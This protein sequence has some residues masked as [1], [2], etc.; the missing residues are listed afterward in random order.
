MTGLQLRP[1]ELAD[2]PAITALQARYDVHWFGAP[3]RDDDEMAEELDNAAESIVVVDGDSL[4]AIVWTDPPGATLTIDPTVPSGPVLDVALGWLKEREAK[5]EVLSRDEVLRTA[6]ADAGWAHQRSAFELMR[7]ADGDWLDE[8]EWPAGITVT[9]F[10]AATPAQVHELIYR[11]AR[12]ADVVGHVDRDLAD[13]TS[14]FVTDKDV[15]AQ[16][17][18]AWRDGE[19]V[20]AA[21]GRIFADGSGWIAQLA[22]ARSQRRSGLGR[23]LL[24]EGLRRRVAAG[25]TTLGLSVQADNAA[26][27]ALYTGV[28][29]EVVREWQVFVGS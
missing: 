6:F 2:R 27:I 14:I 11:D 8:P 10:D 28:G 20:G 12:W 9:D 16:Q 23:A 25:A 13:W 7:S 5:V 26:A 19:L 21:T 15:A 22:V 24:L 18:L 17:V 29:L 3:E 1:A 4:V